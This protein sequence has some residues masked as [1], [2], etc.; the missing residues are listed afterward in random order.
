[1]AS[2]AKDFQVAM[3]SEV[4][5]IVANATGNDSYNS[6]Y[7]GTTTELFYL[8]SFWVQSL[9]NSGA[10]SIGGLYV[11]EPGGAS[12]ES[13]YTAGL[14]NSEYRDIAQAFQKPLIIPIDHDIWVYSLSADMIVTA[15]ITGYEKTI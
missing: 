10:F 15:G 4:A 11:R 9:N 1:M 2:G 6:L 8:C 12:W 13:I 7:L 14:E 3:S 5:T